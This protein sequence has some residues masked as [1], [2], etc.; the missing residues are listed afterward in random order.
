MRL[1]NFGFVNILVIHTVFVTV[2]LLRGEIVDGHIQADL[3]IEE[4]DVFQ[5]FHF[6]LKYINRDLQR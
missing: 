5:G 1:T 4:L 6:D 2:V 3:D